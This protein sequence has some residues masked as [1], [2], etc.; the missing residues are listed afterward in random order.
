MALLDGHLVLIGGV[1][2]SSVEIHELR[3]D[4]QWIS[5]PALPESLA[6]SCAVTAGDKIIVIGGHNN[7]STASLDIVLQYESSASSWTNLPGKTL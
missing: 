1:G 6:R 2:H 5:G 3:G 4:K 7:D